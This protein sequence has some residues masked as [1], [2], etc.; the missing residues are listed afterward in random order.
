MASLRELLGTEPKRAEVIDDAL[1]VLDAEVGDKRGLGGVAVKGAYK[2]VKGVR[3]GFTRNA[4][5]HLLDDFLDALDPFYQQALE[6]GVTP[7]A[8]VAQRDSEVAES[9]LAVTDGRA[10]TSQ[11]RMVKKTY[12]KLRGAA[13]NHVRAA[14]PRL[15]EML[16]RHADNV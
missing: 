8:Y 13:L 11:N 10:R 2:M 6:Q 9:L 7:S 1:L 15:A 16:A 3:P 5:N 4:V 14:T 12:E